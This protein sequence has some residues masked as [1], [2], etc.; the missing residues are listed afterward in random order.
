MKRIVALLITTA[1]ALSLLAAAQR[2][3]TAKSATTSGSA[4]MPAKVDAKAVGD[5]VDLNSATRDQLKALPGVGDA[6]ADKI[7]AGR[8]YANKAQLVSKNIVPKG[9][10]D[11]FARLVIAKQEHAALGTGQTTKHR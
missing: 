3:A 9:V 10:Y 2:T 8:P 1:L 4:K 5:L 7:V 11:K 6:Y